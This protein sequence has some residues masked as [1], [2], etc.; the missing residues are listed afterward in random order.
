MKK[1][2]EKKYV[3][4]CWALVIFFGIFVVCGIFMPL[5]FIPAAICFAAAGVITFKKLKCPNCG[6]VETLDRL[7]HAVKHEYRC[8]RCRER[9][10]VK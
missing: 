5:L 7:S 1:Y 10:I 9:I 6:T 4:I 3:Y 8:S 2:I